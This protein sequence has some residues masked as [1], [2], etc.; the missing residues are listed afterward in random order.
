MDEEKSRMDK[1]CPQSD[2]NVYDRCIEYRKSFPIHFRNMKK[3][4]RPFALNFIVSTKS[5]QT[6]D[7]KKNIG[8]FC[9]HFYDYYFGSL[10]VHLENSLLFS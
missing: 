9:L 7:L 4:P 6:T 3:L 10:I 5:R 2:D 8:I 1:L